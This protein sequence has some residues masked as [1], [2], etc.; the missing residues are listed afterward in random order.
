MA[1]RDDPHGWIAVVD[2]DAPRRLTL[3][4]RGDIA[5]GFRRKVFSKFE[6]NENA[7]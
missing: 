5:M 6:R 4:E 1:N 7:D 3:C 2:S